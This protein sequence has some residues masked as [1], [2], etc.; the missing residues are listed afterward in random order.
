MMITVLLVAMLQTAPSA[1]EAAKMRGVLLAG[2]KIESGWRNGLSLIEYQTHVKDFGA[3]RLL[4]TA[5]EP[6][7]NTLLEQ[8]ETLLTAGAVLWRAKIF[9]NERPNAEAAAEVVGT[10]LVAWDNDFKFRVAIDSAV[11]L[12]RA[13]RQIV[14]GERTAGIAL[15]DATLGA[16]RA[17]VDYT[18]PEAQ[19]ERRKEAAAT[20]RANAVPLTPEELESFKAR[21]LAVDGPTKAADVATE[22]SKRGAAGTKPFAPILMSLLKTYSSEGFVRIAIYDAFK[23]MGGEAIE[24]LPEL[25]D[26]ATKAVSAMA[27][28]AVE[29]IEKG[30]A[31]K[32]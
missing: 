31:A 23:N 5:K 10:R 29:A 16:I 26:I 24:I 14:N 30:A 32:K 18:S 21:L 3:E 6:A 7:M 4:V 25:R 19:A 22:L 8:T 15:A 9:E 27:M 11:A 20:G 17:R 28:D 13:F 12:I 1:A 2:A